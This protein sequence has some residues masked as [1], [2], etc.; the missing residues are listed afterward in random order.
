M[1]ENDEKVIDYEK[2]FGENV[3]DQIEI[4]MYFEENLKIRNK[5]EKTIQKGIFPGK[6]SLVDHVT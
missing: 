3:K 4:A 6:H 5:L 1:R 2:I